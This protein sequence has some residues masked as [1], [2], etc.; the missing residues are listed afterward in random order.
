M[1][2]DKS[3]SFWLRSFIV[4][5]VTLDLCFYSISSRLSSSCKALRSVDSFILSY[6]VWA[7]RWTWSSS[8]VKAWI[9]CSIT[10]KCS[11][12]HF[13]KASFVWEIIW[14]NFKRGEPLQ[15]VCHASDITWWLELSRVQNASKRKGLG[16]E[17]WVPVVSGMMGEWSEVNLG[18][19][20]IDAF[21]KKSLHAEL[22]IPLS[23]L[24]LIRA[25]PLLP[26][27]QV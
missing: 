20:M 22:Q 3:K 9:F 24:S 12:F 2:V 1:M 10:P 15:V 21:G 6:S 18:R 5:Q 13:F 19:L 4:S 16:S 14:H 23:S 27:T 8:S 7:V 26:L 25:L 11:L 17:E